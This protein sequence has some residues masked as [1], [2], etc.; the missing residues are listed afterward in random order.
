MYIFQFLADILGPSPIVLDMAEAITEYN[1]TAR[2]FYEPVGRMPGQWDHWGERHAPFELSELSVTGQAY[3]RT[4]GHREP[5]ERMARRLTGAKGWLVGYRFERC[6]CPE[7]EGECTCGNGFTKAY[8]PVWY[9]TVARLSQVQMPDNAYFSY[10]DGS[11]EIAPRLVFMVERPWERITPDRWSFGDLK[12]PNLNTS[13]LHL[14]VDSENEAE[15]FDYRHWPMRLGQPPKHGYWWRRPL[16]WMEDFPWIFETCVGNWSAGG[17]LRGYIGS[18]VYTSDSNIQLQHDPGVNYLYNPGDWPAI[19]RLAFT[20]FSWLLVRILHNGVMQAEIEIREPVSS[21][22]Y[23]YIDTANGELS[24]RYCPVSADPCVDLSDLAS[25]VPEASGV[26]PAAVIV[27]G[28]L[29][30]CIRPG[31]TRMEVSGFRMPSLPFSWSYDLTP[32]YS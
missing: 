25:F 17:W 32:L 8:T 31:L 28:N 24:V 12:H 23:L 26:T 30:E 3:C 29:I 2:M 16:E 15:I 1:S 18:L 20:N 5:V 22:Q 13:V 6:C 11:G 7:C 27:R 9:A 19:C 4:G 21:P 14:G 10:L